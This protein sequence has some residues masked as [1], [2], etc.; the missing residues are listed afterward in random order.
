MSYQIDPSFGL[1]YMFNVSFS[2]E[3]AFSFA[4]A[5]SLANG[6]SRSRTFGQPEQLSQL[7]AQCLTQRYVL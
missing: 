6:K 3:R 5:H 4:F 1:T 2:I 7:N